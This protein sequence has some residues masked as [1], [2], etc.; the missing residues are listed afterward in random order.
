MANLELKG[1]IRA[2]GKKGASRKLRA[3]GS[4]PCVVYGR[5]IDTVSASI[6]PADFAKIL[7]T[8]AGANVV[9]DLVINDNGKEI[10]HTVMVKSVQRDPVSRKIIHA[11]FYA[12]EA[13]RKVL[14]KVPLRLEGRAAGVALGGKLRSAAR[15]VVVSCLPK[16]IP[17]VVIFDVTPM[18]IKDRAQI[19]AV[20]RPEGCEFVYHNDFLV[21]EIFPPRS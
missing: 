21:A 6:N 8:E 16:D 4:I 7:S 20:P 17:T 13:D 1:E 2:A 12:V 14:V 19:S 3:A 18:G 9:F 15:E 11:D 10:R 5:T